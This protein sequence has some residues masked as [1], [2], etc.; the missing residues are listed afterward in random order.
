MQWV[1]GYYVIHDCNDPRV[2]IDETSSLHYFDVD[3]RVIA[4]RDTA[5]E[6]S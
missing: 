4:I 2:A 6:P 1:L 3:P 5:L